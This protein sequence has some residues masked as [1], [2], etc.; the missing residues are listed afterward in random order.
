MTAADECPRWCALP[1]DHDLDDLD[2]DG[3]RHRLHR[4]RAVD[5]GGHPWPIELTRFDVVTLEGVVTSKTEIDDGT[6]VP[7]TAAEARELAHALLA[8]ADI[9]D[10][11]TTQI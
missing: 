5:L 7:L 11:T 3:R 4:G 6:E 1:A 8:A 9:L 10:G 2:R